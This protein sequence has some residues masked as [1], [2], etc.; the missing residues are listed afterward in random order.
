MRHLLTLV[1]EGV[2]EVVRR[3]SR[4]GARRGPTAVHLGD[5]PARQVARQS[6]GR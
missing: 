2:Q 4:A 3:V 6:Q 1:A 5:A